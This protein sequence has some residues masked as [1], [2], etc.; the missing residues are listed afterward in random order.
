MAWRQ[1]RRDVKPL[2]AQEDRRDLLIHVGKE[3]KELIKDEEIAE[4]NAELVVESLIKKYPDKM[5]APLKKHETTE[6]KEG[7]AKYVGQHPYHK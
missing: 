3:I 1:I 5:K 4:V 6:W 7:K 2:L